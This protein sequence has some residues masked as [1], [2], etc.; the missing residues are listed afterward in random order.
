MQTISM[1]LVSSG[2]QTALD[3][4]GILVIIL[5]GS[6]IIVLVADL[7][8]SIFD[9]HEGVFFNRSKKKK[10][11]SEKYKDGEVI[12]TGENVGKKVT[13]KDTPEVVE[14]KDEKTASLEVLGIKE[15]PSS[16]QI[17]MSPV[18]MQK[19]EE[20]ERLLRQKF[21]EANSEEVKPIV[22]EKPVVV[23]E[24]D[25]ESV[26]PVILEQALA[27]E[28]KFNARPVAQEPVVAQLPEPQPS[29]AKIIYKVQ[30]DEEEPAPVVE[31]DVLKDAKEGLF[32][33]RKHMV[34]NKDSIEAR[35]EKER[36]K[37]ERERLAEEQRIRL[38]EERLRVAEEERNRKIDES[39]LKKQKLRF[40]KEKMKLIQQQAD[41][42]SKNKKLEEAN[43]KLESEV[44]S[45]KEELNSPKKPYYSKDYYEKKL[46]KLEEKLKVA[47][48][49]LRLNKRDFIPLRKIKKAYD[50]DS[51]KLSRKEALVAKQKIALYGSAAPSKIDPEKKAKLDEDVKELNE[52]KDSVYNCKQVLSKNKDKYPVLEK[53]HEILS[54]NVED[55]EAEIESVKE[56]LAWYE[57]N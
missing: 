6:F 35:K 26:L 23:E 8:L 29:K 33:M 50:R 17:I 40:A 51:V 14:V 53:A 22:K 32:K 15:K 39:E 28:A 1:Q 45:L 16:D 2:M 11:G 27:E 41:Q 34:L 47:Q 25:L 12:Y 20:E 48:K 44:A 43:K 24:D 21:A 49:E 36:L 52:L 54:K 31:E 5:F 9:K 42:T 30:K 10:K 19:A 38:E 37:Q 56:A 57:N 4:I 46:V 7:L 3:I 55:T 18:D 13:P